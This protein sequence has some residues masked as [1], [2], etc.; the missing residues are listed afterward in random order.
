MFFYIKN[1]HKKIVIVGKTASGKDYLLNEFYKSHQF[2]IGVKHTTRPMRKNE[3]EGLS[4]HFTCNTAF[5]LIVERKQMFVYQEF[6]LGENKIWK[7]GFTNLE[8]EN[9]KVFMLTPYEISFIPKDRREEFII[10]YLDIDKEIRKNRLIK[11]GDQN[12]SI[13]R[14][15]DADESDFY[16]FKDYDIK[17][18][19]PNFTFKEI[20]EYIYLSQT[21]I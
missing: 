5:D 3:M 6:N 11:R 9:N 12:D 15:I 8:I 7:Y 14:R 20:I 18:T 16:N 13:D 10:I 1:M 19:K 21:P 2:K 4:Y 17:I